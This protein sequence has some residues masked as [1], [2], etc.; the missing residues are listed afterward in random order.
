MSTATMSVMWFCRKVR[1]VG[2][3]YLGRHGM[4]LPTVAWL[5]STPSL[6]SSPWI[7]GAPQSGLTRLIWRI[8][9]RVSELT[10]GRPTEHDVDRH[11]QY[12]RKPL[13]CHWI[14]VEADLGAA[15]AARQL[16]VEGRRAQVRGRR[17]DGSGKRARRRR[18]KESYSCPRRYGRGAKISRPSRHFGVSSRDSL[19][20]EQPGHDAAKP[21]VRGVAGIALMPMLFH[22]V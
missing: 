1:Q 11:R 4:Y 19:E 10:L 3:G 13:R 9:S 15:A 5:T 2:E 14:T 17:G 12:S 18:R 20:G 16:D 21:H 8:R 7:R 6:S 22:L